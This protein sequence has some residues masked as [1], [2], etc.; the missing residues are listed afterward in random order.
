MISQANQK[1]MSDLKEDRGRKGVKL[2]DARKRRRMRKRNEKR[3]ACLRF[4][5]RSTANMV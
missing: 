3:R 2:C 5:W 4:L 1:T